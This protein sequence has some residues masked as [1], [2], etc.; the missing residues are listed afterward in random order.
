MA[1]PS[2]ITDD[3]V[4]FNITSANWSGS[5][6]PDW[7]KECSIVLTGSGYGGAGADRFA[8]SETNPNDHT[9]RLNGYRPLVT[10]TYSIPRGTSEY[11]WI[12]PLPYTYPATNAD[13]VENGDWTVQ[14]TGSGAGVEQLN[15]ATYIDKKS[16]AK[17]A[18][19]AFISSLNPVR[20]DRV[21]LATYSYSSTN[22]TSSQT[23]YVCE[24]NQWEG[25]FTVNTGGVYY[26]NLTWANASDNLDLCLYDGI[27]VLNSSATGSNPETVS[28][29]LL[30][31]TD[32][33][34]VVN[35]TNVTGNDTRFTI[36]V[37]SSPLRDVMC[38]YR[39]SDSLTSKKIPRYR[40][41][42]GG[43]GR[44]KNLRIT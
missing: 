23:T 24:G 19:H 32:Y 43:I 11:I 33:R 15:I 34:V 38:A 29:T 13:T 27:T 3:V 41:W 2:S 14:V 20:E 36:N 22:E 28:A 12:H 9:Y 4:E 17:L 37:S 16:A 6:L 18:P 10:I 35:G 8:S 7:G 40:Q 42:E 39:N 25:Y 1:L 26:F 5:R 31:G 21:G 44:M 30:T